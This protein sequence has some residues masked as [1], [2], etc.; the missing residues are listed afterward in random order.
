MKYLLIKGTG[1]IRE[2]QRMPSLISPKDVLVELG[3]HSL[4]N[5]VL[6]LDANRVDEDKTSI[7]EREA[8]LATANK[9]GIIRKAA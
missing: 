2:F 3:S 4:V 6:S 1:E 9:L 5:H 7:P 8:A